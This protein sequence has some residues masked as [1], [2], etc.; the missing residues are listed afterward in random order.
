MKSVFA[1]TVETSRPTSVAS[2]IR[3][4][5]EGRLGWESEKRW[6]LTENEK[7]LAVTLVKVERLVNGFLVV[8]AQRCLDE[9]TEGMR[10]ETNVKRM[11]NYL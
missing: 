6:E 5:V 9:K 1:M 4:Q 8:E 2:A 11:M 10:E 3:M 7:C